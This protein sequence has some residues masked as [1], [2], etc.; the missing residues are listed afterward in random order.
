M[1]REYDEYLD[2]IDR[3]K[4]DTDSIKTNTLKSLFDKSDR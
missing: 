1:S 2:S 3:H 4:E